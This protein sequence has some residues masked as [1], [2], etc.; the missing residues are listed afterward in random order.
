MSIKFC[1]FFFCFSFHAHLFNICFFTFLGQ[2]DSSDSE[3]YQVWHL[4]TFLSG[5]CVSSCCV[6][7]PAHA[8][9]CCPSLWL[10]C[11]FL[12]CC[13]CGVVVIRYC[14]FFWS[15]PFCILLKIGE[16]WH[17]PSGLYDLHGKCDSAF[18]FFTCDSVYVADNDV[19]ICVCVCVVHVC[20]CSCLCVCVCVYVCVLIHMCVRA[21]VCVCVTVR[22]RESMGNFLELNGTVCDQL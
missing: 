17:I 16:V 21:C 10:R 20:L 2:L 19:T 7:I 6:N 12:F 8:L 15:H 1:S 18:C 4:P 5:M 11:F 3:T 14:W 13:W 22:E 9:F